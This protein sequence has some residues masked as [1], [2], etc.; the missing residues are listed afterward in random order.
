MEVI[1]VLLNMVYD[2]NFPESRYLWNIKSIVAQSE[3]QLN[4]AADLDTHKL[5][6]KSLG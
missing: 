4:V 3:W 6:R 1:S 5:N 2:T